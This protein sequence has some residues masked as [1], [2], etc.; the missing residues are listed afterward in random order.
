LEGMPG[1][2]FSPPHPLM[3]DAPPPP[4][5]GKDKFQKRSADVSLVLHELTDAIQRRDASVLERILTEDYIGIVGSDFS[6]YYN[7]VRQIAMVETGDISIERSEFRNLLVHPSGGGETALISTFTGPS[8]F[9]IRGR[10]S[11]AECWHYLRLDKQNEQWTVSA[12]YVNQMSNNP[13]CMEFT[14]TP[15]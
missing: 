2:L 5:A 4:S 12:I 11:S 13:E 9:K 10:D 3:C 7:K 15:E 14:F 8:L 6:N 1:W